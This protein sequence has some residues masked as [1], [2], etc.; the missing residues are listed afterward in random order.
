MALPDGSQLFIGDGG[1]ETTMI[2]EE[3]FELPEFASFTLLR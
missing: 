3:G 1:L 2:F